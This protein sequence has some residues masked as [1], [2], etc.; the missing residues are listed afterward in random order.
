MSAIEIKNLSYTYSQKTPYEKLA[1]SHID[2]TVEEG[3]FI[4]IAGATGSG[5]STLIQHLNGLIRLQDKKASSLVVEGMDLADKKN[6]KKVRFTV[7]MVFQYP[8]YQLFE[9]TIEKD[10]AYGPTNMKL[11]AQEVKERVRAAM[12][13]VGLDYDE[14]AGRSPFDLSGGEKRRV[15]IAGV[16]AMRPR[17]LVLDEPVAGLDPVG[18]EDM[19]ALLKKLQREVSPT[20][21]MVS[22]NMDDLARIADRIIVIKDGK[23]VADGAPKRV[24]SDETA[25][26]AGLDLPLAARLARKLRDSGLDIDGDIISMSELEEALVRLKAEREARHV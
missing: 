22:H 25:L 2:L 17:V 6:L 24:F 7:G 26:A 1:L 9:D 19:L 4:G 12:E 21:V 18:K 23:K 13:V 15:A 8:E 10:I 11:P 14:F 3:E 5:K 16:I 20:V